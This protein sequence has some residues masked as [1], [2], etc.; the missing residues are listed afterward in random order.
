MYLSSTSC[1]LTYTVLDV[2][3]VAL[4]HKCKKPQTFG[5]GKS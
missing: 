3:T 4:S 2:I 1:T 5:C